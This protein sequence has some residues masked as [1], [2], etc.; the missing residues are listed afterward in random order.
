M[1]ANTAAQM[2]PTEVGAGYDPA[3]G[4][5]GEYLDPAEL[6]AERNAQ[7]TKL[8]TG[9]NPEQ[10]AAVTH[11]GSALLVVAGAGSG[12]TRVLTHR[13]AHLIATGRARPFEILAITFTNK[14]AAEMSERTVA[15]IGNQARGMWVSTFHSACVRILRKHADALGLKSTFTIYDQ[16][17]AQRLMTMVC[18]DLNLDPKQFPPKNFSRRVSDL[19]NELVDP[20]A[21]GESA[22]ADPFGQHLVT[23]YQRYQERLKEANAVDF[24][25]L[26]MLTVQLL[27]TQPAVAEM[28]HRRFRHILIDEYQ[29]TNHAQYMLAAL[30]TG[31]GSDGVPPA[32]LTVVGDSDQSIYA[33]RGATIRNIEEFEKD[34]PNARVITLNQ[35]YRSTQ[36]ILSGANAIISQNQNRRVKELWSDL[37][38]GDKIVIDA[39]PSDREEANFI[40][41]EID[42]LAGQY[43]YGDFAVF[44]RTNAQSRAIEEALTRNGIPYRVVGGTKFYDRAE[45][46]DAIAYLQLTHNPD[47]VVAFNR[48][49][50][51]PRRGIGAKAIAMVNE[52]ANTYQQS[53]GA[54]MARLVLSQG[55]ASEA[56][57]AEIDELWPQ[58]GKLPPVTGLSTRAEKS[59]AE[60]A[61]MIFQSRLKIAEGV[62]VL[63]DHLLDVSGYLAALRASTDLQDVSRIEN[64]AELHSVASEFEQLQNMLEKELPPDVER[65]DHLA[66]FLEK[67][68]LVSDT[69][70]LPNQDDQGEV[71]L[72]TVHTAKGLEFPVVF[73]TGMEDGTFPHERAMYSQSELEEE[74]RLAYV[75]ITRARKRLYLTRAHMRTAWGKSIEKVASRFLDELPAEIVL[76]TDR[77]LVPSHPFVS[78]GWGGSYG[79]SYPRSGREN[80]GGGVGGYRH[81]RAPRSEDDDFAPAIGSGQGLRSTLTGSERPVSPTAAARVAKRQQQSGASAGASGDWPNYPAGTRVTHSAYGDGTVRETSGQGA[82]LVYHIDFDNGTSKRIM[83]RF[84]KV[85]AI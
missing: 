57:Q 56:V 21:Y 65:G 43:Q 3:L 6:E 79:S 11:G 60:F 24:D 7:I 54:A 10:S 67:V 42:E 20:H 50:N 49:V 31:D 81:V 12:K 72:M 5:A 58:I 44:Y 28:Y 9:L 29:D 40:I 16:T 63:L 74:R 30:L 76:E 15:L 68:A 8:L 2:V 4:P 59:L 47:D 71:T 52:W 34:Y 41:K 14:A 80:Y 82:S 17:D 36:N 84:K 78:T 25:D 33:F 69:D 26:I 18:K 85:T 46:K 75:A 48:I 37:G 38:Q 77:T 39:A 45:I 51:T 53:T 55:N 64:L 70:Q 23:V 83:A 73:V 13:I 66:D 62:A 19:K 61:A 1:A 27:Q 32:E 35:N 22:P